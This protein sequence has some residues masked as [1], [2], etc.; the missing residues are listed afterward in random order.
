MKPGTCKFYNGSH[1]NKTCDAGVEYR[2][3]LTE[4]DRLTGSA[5]RLPCILKWPGSPLSPGQQ[6]EFEKRGTC[7]KFTEPSKDDLAKYEA[8]MAAHMA[9]MRK[10]F[11][12]MSSIRK[13]HK[14]VDW[15]GIVACPAC[16]GKLHMRHAAY[17]GHT[18]GT[19]ETE[20]C[21][22]WIE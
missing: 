5:F 15:S 18:A 4:P 13:E 17:N 2:S 16:G 22:R 1:H 9:K 10:T 21:V 20:G 19:C 6:A 3:V 12:L 14:G 8:E 11:T 7:P